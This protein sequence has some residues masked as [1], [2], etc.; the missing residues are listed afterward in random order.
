MIFIMFWDYLFYMIERN[1]INWPVD[2]TFTAVTLISVWSLAY[3]VDNKKTLAELKDSEQKA[4][5]LSDEKTGSWTIC[6]KS[7]FRRMLKGILHI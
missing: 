6:R 2:I 1:P 7:F 5:A 3:Y 4:K